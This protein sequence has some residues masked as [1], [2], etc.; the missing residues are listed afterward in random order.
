[1]SRL[2]LLAL[3]FLGVS[4]PVPDPVLENDAGDAAFAQRATWLMWGRRPTSAAE[5]DVLV[6][7]IQANDRAAVVRE[8]AKAPDYVDRWQEFLYDALAVNRN[9]DR[10]NSLCYRIG[11]WDDDPALAAYVASASASET[12]I[13]PWTMRDLVRSALLLDDLSPAFRGGLLP[14][15][16]MPGVP[17]NLIE[18]EADR[19]DFASVFFSTHLGRNPECLP[20]HNSEA[21]VTDHEDPDVDRFWPLPGT[22]ERDLFGASEGRDLDSLGI[23][24]RRHGVAHGFRIDSFGVGDVYPPIDL[25][26]GPIPEDFDGCA[27]LENA[28]EPGCGGCFC[29]ARVCAFDPGCCE[30][31]WDEFCAA[32]CVDALDG[33]C[34]YHQEEG[35]SDPFQP[36][37]M[38]DGCGVFVRPDA[39]QDDVSGRE[40]WFGGPLGTDA[41]AYALEAALRE[42]FD[43]LRTEG[44]SGA[45]GGP[46]AGARLI[47]ARLVDRVWAEAFGR[48]LTISHGF[49]R[50]E[51]QRDR[52]LGL[53]HAFV[54]GGYSL[55]DV[56]VAVTSDPLFNQPLPSEAEAE[57]TYYFPPVLDPW[58]IEAEDEDQRGNG[59]GDAVHRPSPRILTRAARA[60]LQWR[61]VEGF[62]ITTGSFHG[63]FQARTGAYLTWSEPGFQGIDFQWLSAWEARLSACVEP[64]WDL[65]GDGC[66]PD[67]EQLGC[68]GCDCFDGVCEERPQCCTGPWDAACA[69]SC[70]R[71]NACPVDEFRDTDWIDRLV[72]TAAEEGVDRGTTVATLKDRLV[73]DATL[74]DADERV[75]LERIVGDLDATT[76]TGDEAAIREVCGALLTSPQFLLAGLPLP[77]SESATLPMPGETVADRCADLT[78]WMF[79]PAICP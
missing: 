65:R 18:A 49:P 72:A 64:V 28:P 33:E 3:A 10:A 69:E 45:G 60:A 44:M 26:G 12:D 40:G 78:T 63:A 79:T 27:P 61:D 2:L 51:G 67:P 73:S 21:S 24:F 43:A 57:T 32:S 19:R 16:A 74:T 30:G 55:V 54:E 42:G 75:L 13:A 48:P 59:L 68:P 7:M 62:P 11:Y 46:A 23:F 35:A 52:L 9:G 36:W 14:N 34:S 31:P 70:R 50:N 58:S 76:G 77:A 41:S 38:H 22:P 39:V 5:R 66:E 47:V 56:L 25:E 8:M 29:E 71:F 15:A 17:P 6:H 4:C 20:C 37:N 53:S 1:V